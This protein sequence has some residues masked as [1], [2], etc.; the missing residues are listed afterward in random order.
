M[1]AFRDKLIN[2]AESAQDETEERS[3]GELVDLKNEVAN[4]K[5]NVT[6]MTPT[7]PEI[8]SWAKKAFKEAVEA[9]GNSSKDLDSLRTRMDFQGVD[10]E[11]ESFL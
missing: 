5:D 4:N 1:E 10:S 7:D 8:A 2:L 9:A 6:S 11:A 3:R